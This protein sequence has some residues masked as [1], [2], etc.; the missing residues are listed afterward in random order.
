[1]ARPRK[2]IDTLGEG[3]ELLGLFKK[4]K[5]G[6]K[7]ECLPAIKRILEEVPTQM[8]ADDLGGSQA[9]I[10]ASINKFR[11]G[12]IAELLT[13]SKGNG[14]QSRLTPEIEESM[15]GA[16]ETWTMEDRARCLEMAKRKF[17]CQRP[18]GIR[19]L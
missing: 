19:D 4:E 18:Q 2:Q 8:V 15:I 9:T 7:R 6:W 10:Q 17:R 12:G 13:K 1:M 11:S 16:T 5:P 3:P 14:P